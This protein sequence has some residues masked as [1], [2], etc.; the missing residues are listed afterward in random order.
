VKVYG[1]Y[2]RPDGRKHVVLYENGQ[3]TTVSYP[4]WLMEQ[5]LGRKLEPNETVH[6]VNGDF[7]DD[8][9][10]NLQVIDKHDHLRLHPE[11]IK[12]A[13]QAYKEKYTGTYRHGTQYAWQKMKCKCDACMKA[14]WEWND[15]RNESRRT[16]KRGPYKR[17]TEKPL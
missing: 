5:K 12:K 3:R 10:D 15:K 8:R 7:T 9:L 2:S 14:K 11:S 6:H 16:G 1:P 17:R 4:K 13:V